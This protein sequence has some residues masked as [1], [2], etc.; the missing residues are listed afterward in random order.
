MAGLNCPFGL[1]LSLGL[2]LF[3]LNL[4]AA[5]LGRKFKFLVLGKIAFKSQFGDGGSGGAEGK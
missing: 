1:R 4:T 2:K 3:R 5:F